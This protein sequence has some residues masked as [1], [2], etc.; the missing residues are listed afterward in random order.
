MPLIDA[1]GTGRDFDAALDAAAA[2]L[3]AGGV[4]GIP[5]ETVYGLAAAPGVDGAT[6]AVFSLKGRPGGAPLP[7]IVAGFDQAASLAEMEGAARVLAAGLWPG[8][9]TLVVSRRPGIDWDLGGDPATIGLRCPDHEVA[10]ELC[11]RCGPLVATSA[12]RHGEPALAGAAE[13]VDSFPGLVVLDGGECRGVASTV[14]D[15]TGAE[16]GLLRAGAVAWEDVLAA[17]AVGGWGP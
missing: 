3:A 7:V 11:R 15:L 12:N 10:R 5:T 8:G 13:V 6:E 14:V 9:L 17:L 1:T 4:V 16:P 2:A